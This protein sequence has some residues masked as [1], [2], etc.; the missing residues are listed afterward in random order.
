MVEKQVTRSSPH[1]KGG[2]TQG[3]GFEGAAIVGSFLVAAHHS[4]TVVFGAL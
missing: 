3:H 4:Y 1:L 2:M